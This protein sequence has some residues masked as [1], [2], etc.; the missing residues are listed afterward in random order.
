MPRWMK[1]YYTAL[2]SSPED[3]EITTI[4]DPMSPFSASPKYVE[5]AKRKGG[6]PTSMMLS[7]N[8]RNGW[9]RDIAIMKVWT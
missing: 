5:A 9:P 1:R 7:R 6:F 2:E 3:M 8:H 4:M